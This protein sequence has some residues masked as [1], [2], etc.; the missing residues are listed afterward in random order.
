MA[1]LL[2]RHSTN[3]AYF[4]ALIVAIGAAGCGSG[5][6]PTGQPKVRDASG[7]R[8]DDQ[9][10]A[11]PAVQMSREAGLARIRRL[12][13]S[14]KIDEAYRVVQK[15]LLQYPEDSDAM[16]LAAQASS[17]RGQ[18][19]QA[20]RLLD[21]A[22]SLEPESG[23]SWRT[24]AAVM[25][26]QAGRW[27]EATRRLEALVAEYP[28]FDD[29]RSRLADLLNL[30]GFR[31]DANEHIRLLCRRSGVTP[32]QLRGLMVPAR[33]HIVFAKKPDIENR[34]EVEKA[35]SL[36]VA[37]A[38]L[39]EG[40]VRD[41]YEVLKRSRLV[42]Q[43]NPCAFAFYGQALI[44]SQHF[45]AFEDWL[46]AAGPE[47]QRYPAYWLAVG[48]W[49]M[50]H[51]QYSAAVRMFAEAVLR[52]PGDAAANNRMLQALET[53]GH[54]EESERFRQRGVQMEDLIQLSKKI[55]ADPSSHMEEIV[56]LA[57]GLSDVGR[58]LESLGWYQVAVQMMGP[59]PEAMHAMDHAKRLVSQSERDLSSQREILCDINLNDFPLDLSLVSAT[60]SREHSADL[61]SSPDRPRRQPS[62]VNVASMVGVDFQYRNAPVSVE[63]ELRMFQQPGAG[64]ACLDYDLNGSVDLYVAQ[65]S[66]D[67][68]KGLGTRPN[69]LTRNLGNRFVDIT[70]AAGCDDRG[71]TCGVTSGDWNQDGFPD[72][73]VGNML[74]NALFINQG[75]GTFRI[76]S[77][78]SVWN[79]PKF[80]AS[81]A[82]ADVDGDHLPDIVE[83]NYLDDPH[84]YDAIQYRPDGTPILPAPGQFQPSVDRI[85]LSRGDGSMSGQV[86]GDSAGSNAASGLGVLVTNVDGKLGN[87]IFVA[88]DHMANQFWERVKDSDSD[89]VSWQNS[90]AVRGVAYGPNG[91]PL[92][93]MGIAS[94]DFDENGRLDLH[95]TNFDDQWSNL[96]MQ[97]A[98]G[99][100][101]DL[102]VA[103]GLDRPTFKMVGFGTQAIDY[104]NNSVIDL[105]IGNGHIDG[106]QPK[107]SVFEM[108][109]QI[110][111]FEASQFVPLQVTGDPSYWDQDHVSRA[112]AVCDWNNDGRVD[113]VVTDLIHPLALLEN[114]TNTNYHWLQLQLVG[115]RGERDAIGSTVK[116]IFGNQ[117]I[118]KVITA[119]DGY[120][121]KNQS[122]VCFGLAAADTVERL[123]ILW[124]DGVSQT[125]RAVAADRRWLVVQGED[126]PFA[127]D[128]P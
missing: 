46:S 53:A 63:R 29:A 39:S 26:A 82:M 44:E 35:G 118:T 24:R 25:L 65:A 97:N 64:V 85:F 103:F 86:L 20:V 8:V 57:Q 13:S 128:R 66:G 38:L 7:D 17:A 60:E 1:F 114:R 32:D 71:Y 30:R 27:Q 110:F 3:I 55:H 2:S 12:I 72:L 15:H 108:P 58:S 112:L 115:T 80:T 88:N 96:F 42:E 119:G 94:A 120:M 11:T 78:D 41:A 127:F 104:D 51:R 95:V 9:A 37:R 10:R 122:L 62:F 76:Q 47:C 68:P 22:A 5:W 84:I 50:R 121:S 100:F 14:G 19:D 18:I 90:A 99:L 107:G 43:K 77:G 105:V 56:E 61:S 92:G 111:A 23:K 74:R 109:T 33:S 116:A 126:E 28:D 34:E 21:N 106:V 69:L 113:F 83:V 4:V 45:A 81:L 123:E 117:S 124:P 59:S 54:I 87:E 89:R 36:S 6:K 125:L 67:P 40:D 49:A 79:D 91:K 73:V 102:V 70:Q 101:D 16:L 52:E 98:D 48:G 75:D 93:C 31:F